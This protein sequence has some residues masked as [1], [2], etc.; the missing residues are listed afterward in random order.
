MQKV[1]QDD[2]GLQFVIFQVGAQNFAVEITRVKEI[3]RYQQPTAI[4]KSPAFLEG[5]IEVRG[6]LIPVVDLRK[7]FEISP[8]PS[9]SRT[10]IIILRA[11]KRK[12]GIVVDAV[13]RV[14]SIPLKDIKAPPAIA[15]AHGADPLLAVAKHKNELYVVLD[16]DRILSS[17]Q[18]ISLAKVKLA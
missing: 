9:D 12:V 2:S 5:V 7:R 6:N 18:R 17:V 16:L 15:Q 1:R 3:Q 10:R 11:V 4:P 14:I 13:H 8:N